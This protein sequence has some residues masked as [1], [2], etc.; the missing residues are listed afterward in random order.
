MSPSAGYLC[1]VG[2]PINVHLMRRCLFT[3]SEFR[4]YETPR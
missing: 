1:S 4:I 3:E 2:V